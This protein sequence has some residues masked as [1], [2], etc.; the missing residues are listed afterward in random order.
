MKYPRYAAP[1]TLHEAVTLLAAE[2]EARPIAGGTDLLPRLRAGVLAPELLV[3]LRLLPLTEIA[4]APDCLRIGA[5]VT[6]AG[7][8]ASDVLRDS[9]PA[10]AQACRTVGGPPIR[11][12]GTVG[13]N[14][15][16]ASPAADAAPPLLAFDA[17]VVI[18]SIRGERILP[19][20]DFFLGPG[21]T[22]L[23]PGDILTEIRL[24]WPGPRTAAVY[25][26]LGRRQAMAVAVASVAVRLT[27]SEAGE[28]TAARVALG[29]VAPVPLRALAAE[30]LLSGRPVSDGVGFSRVAQAA[31]AACAPI[32]D[33][34]ASAA[35]RKRMIE[36]LTRRALLR[37]GS[38]LAKGAGHASG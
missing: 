8:A 34:R 29:S 5:C 35:Y 24:P 18:A 38:A 17:Q 2:P 32:S 6:H 19:L 30:A 11:S 23:A 25:L 27:L 3:D 33:L 9:F 31:A 21:R 7:L 12:R 36:V 4:A 14:L 16:N 37:A 22:A 10:L 13:G 15:A 20:N 28:V 26:K 1:A